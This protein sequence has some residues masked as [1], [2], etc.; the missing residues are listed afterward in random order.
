[1]TI[2]KSTDINSQIAN[3][4]TPLGRRTMK[5]H[6]K[7]LLASAVLAATGGLTL[8]TL[9]T[10]ADAREIEDELQDEA[11]IFPYYTVRDGWTTLA[12]VTNTSPFTIIAKVRY[13]ES[14]NSRDVL[15]FNVVLSPFDVWAGWVSEGPNGPRLSTRDNSCTTPIFE[16]AP[17]GSRFADM[18]NLGYQQDGGPKDIDRAREGHFEFITMG[19]FFPGSEDKKWECS[20]SVPPS[21]DSDDG[22]WSGNCSEPDG[23]WTP[24]DT[25][26]P[27][28]WSQGDVKYPTA[29]YAKH[30]NGQPRNCAMV[31]SRFEAT[32]P[33][34]KPS[35]GDTDVDGDPLA[36]WDNHLNRD[37]WPEQWD[38]A[39]D[40][41]KGNFGLVNVAQGTAAGGIPVANSMY[42]DY[43][44]ED[45]ITAQEY[46][47][48]LEP[49]L[50]S[51]CEFNDN[52]RRT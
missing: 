12:N 46:P 10:P 31:D 18:S 15:D 23:G 6:R 19:Q 37:Y 36:E 43:D 8:L 52:R 26:D 24:N 39:D 34:D 1:M 33:F 47:F 38:E 51:A 11:L 2:D 20:G 49:S 32:T 3:Q 7:S 30:E 50:Y 45:L 42:C 5:T 22:D 44:D 9:S 17:D 48:F 40:P 4:S 27:I 16:T 28:S 35:A 21:G 13:R 25:P 29:Y 14:Y 41:L